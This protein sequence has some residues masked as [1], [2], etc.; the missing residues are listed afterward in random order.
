MRMI[1]SYRNKETEQFS[2]GMRVREFESVERAA[3]LKLNKLRDAPTLADIAHLPGNRFE[4]LKGS[5][6]G[7]CSIR[8]N[9]RWRI[10]FTWDDQSQGFA[11]VEIVDYH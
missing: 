7:Q 10:C 6:E 3:R 8:I 9:D 5:R 11:N 1:A 2:L 4:R